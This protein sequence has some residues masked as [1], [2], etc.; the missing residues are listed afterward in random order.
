MSTVY[1]YVKQHS[2]TGLKYFGKTT[3]SNPFKYNGSGKRWLNHIK[4]HGI[5]H[6]KTIDVWGFDDE[7]LCSSFAL[8]FSKQN[9]IVESSDWANLA[10]ENGKN[11]GYRP[12]NTFTWWNALPKT[13]ESNEKRSKFTTQQNYSRDYSLR[14]NQAISTKLKS[15]PI[16]S[17]PHCGANGKLFGR[18]KGVHFDKCKHKHP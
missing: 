1:L 8:E 18:F 11:G 12:N 4:K 9:N 15:Y 5:K 3:S 7:D 14:D 16:V 13:K 10:P 17:C 2:I 6:I